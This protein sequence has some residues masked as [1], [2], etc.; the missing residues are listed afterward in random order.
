MREV[1]LGSLL[2]ALCASGALLGVS[3]RHYTSAGPGLPPAR[4]RPFRRE[5]GLACLRL[6]AWA[7]LL[8]A[9]MAAAGAALYTQFVRD[10]SLGGAVLAGLGGIGGVAGYRFLHLLLFNPGLVVASL[11]CRAS[12]LYPLWQRLSPLRLRLLPGLLAGL[13]VVAWR[14]L[15]AGL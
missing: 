2:A 11:P 4:L 5:M 9:L 10:P 13:L 8:C 7:Y 14:C 1:L 6:M 3:L 15:R 12:R